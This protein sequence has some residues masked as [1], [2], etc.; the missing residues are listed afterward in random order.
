L[1]QRFQGKTVLVGQAFADEDVF[2][3]FHG[4]RSEARHGLELHAGATSAL[5]GNGIVQPL[6]WLGAFILMVALGL[7]GS[8]LS[9]WTPGG[10]TWPKRAVLL[11]TVGICVAVAVALC[12]SHALLVNLTYPL[13]ALLIGF[14][15]AGKLMRM[16]RPG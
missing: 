12:I 14:W 2:E 7:F 8:R 11:A 9:Q 1:R 6:G 5:L 10:R 3:V 15:G 4:W 16:R 13:G